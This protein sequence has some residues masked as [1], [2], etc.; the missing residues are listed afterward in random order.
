[1]A[2]LRH[3]AWRTRLDFWRASK[4]GAAKLKAYLAPAQ[5]VNAGEASGA[6]RSREALQGLRRRDTVAWLPKLLR[7]LWSPYRAPTASSKHDPSS[8]ID[9]AWSQAVFLVSPGRRVVLR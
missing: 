9:T 2:H 4:G 7:A 8:V 6:G 5:R 1:M 3:T